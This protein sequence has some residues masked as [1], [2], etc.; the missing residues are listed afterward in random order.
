MTDYSDG[1]QA[2]IR[3]RI[4]RKDFEFRNNW[5]M[6]ITDEK[7]VNIKG[8]LQRK[9]STRMDVELGYRLPNNPELAFLLED[10][11]GTINIHKIIQ[12]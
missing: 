9:S 12:D 1:W 8:V 4:F 7:D 3:W 5:Y 6:S 11:I 10:L 2:W